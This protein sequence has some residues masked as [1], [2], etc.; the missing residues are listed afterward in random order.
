MFKLIF[1]SM[2]MF[3]VVICTV[4]FFS[5]FSFGS[6]YG[7][8]PIFFVL[9]ISIFWIIGLYFLISGIKQIV[10][11]RKTEN[12]GEEC[13][14]KILNVYPSGTYINNIPELKADI[15]V[16]IPSEGKVEIVSE[17]LGIKGY[18][19]PQGSIFKLKY[20]EGDVNIIK[21]ADEYEVPSNVLDMLGAS[22]NNQYANNDVIEING[23]R[24]M[25]ID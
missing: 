12:L 4:V 11:D 20:Y 23:E 22:D 1:G 24:Y 16:Y 3:I 19:F 8:I 2:W 13:F 25:K 18:N 21:R 5:A 14:G 17:I 10:R 6:G 7:S 9:F 15:S